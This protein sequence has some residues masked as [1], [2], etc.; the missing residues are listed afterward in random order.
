MLLLVSSAEGA[1]SVHFPPQVPSRRRRRTRSA[2]QLKKARTTTASSAPPRVDENVRRGNGYLNRRRI[3]GARIRLVIRNSDRG[4]TGLVRRH[5][6]RHTRRR[7]N[8]SNGRVRTGRI[9]LIVEMR[10]RNLKR[11]SLTNCRK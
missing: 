8:R 5:R 9:K 6:E 10:L 4:G 2:T 11:L 1:D 7:R 3:T